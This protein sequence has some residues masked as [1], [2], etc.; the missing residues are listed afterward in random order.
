LANGSLSEVVFADGDWRVRTLGE[1]YH[2][3]GIEQER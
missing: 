3:R 1:V 2:L